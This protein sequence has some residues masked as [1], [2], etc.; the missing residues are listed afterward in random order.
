MTIKAKL[1]VGVAALSLC[2]IAGQAL[3]GSTLLPGVSTGIPM[4]A[5]LPEGVFDVSIGNRFSV[6]TRCVPGV[7]C[8]GALDVNAAAPAWLIWSTPWNLLGGHIAFDVV[9]PVAQVSNNWKLFNNGT[10]GNI[11][12]IGSPLV[13]MHWK[14]NFGN[15][16][17]AGVQEGVSFPVDNEL[18]A[19]GVPLARNYATFMQ[20][21]AV[22][23][24]K[25]GWNLTATGIFGTGK[26]S[27]SAASALSN[28]GNSGSAW[29]N[30]DLTA[31]HTFGK[32]EVGPIAYGA[33]DVSSP[34]QGYGKQGEFLVGGLVGYNFGPINVQAKLART[35]SEVNYSGYQTSGWVTAIIPLWVAAP[36]PAV[37]AKY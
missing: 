20:L 8:P 17:N 37:V 2:V 19:N 13:S 24:L 1:I 34:Y 29:I 26:N 3:A 21:V 7:G 36:P 10:S 28:A 25:D 27:S 18:S 22:S 14:W 30:L 33:W 15:G 5:P 32:W 6:G 4:G 35:V 9:A 12:G 23:Y 11:S 16:W 31:T